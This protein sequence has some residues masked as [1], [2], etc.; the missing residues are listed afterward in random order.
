MSYIKQNP[1]KIRGINADQLLKTGLYQ[2][3][4][5]S[6]N[7]VIEMVYSFGV[8]FGSI[9]CLFF[10]WRFIKTLRKFKSAR[11]VVRIVFLFGFFPICFWSGSIWVAACWWFW[12]IL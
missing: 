11:D 6:H 7:L 5:T 9:I 8:V 1:Y 10:F 4:N 2:S 12:I 3:S